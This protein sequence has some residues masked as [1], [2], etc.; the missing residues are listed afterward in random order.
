MQDAPTLADLAA[1]TKTLVEAGVPLEDALK[2]TGMND[3]VDDDPVVPP[4]EGVSE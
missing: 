2:A 4:G 1:T 3:P